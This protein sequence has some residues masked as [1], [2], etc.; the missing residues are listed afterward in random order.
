MQNV[1][2][3]KALDTP[4]D[5]DPNIPARMIRGIKGQKLISP[6]CKSNEYLYGSLNNPPSSMKEIS[7]LFAFEIV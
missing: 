5:N 6:K 2:E 1:R 7:N 4:L 3:K